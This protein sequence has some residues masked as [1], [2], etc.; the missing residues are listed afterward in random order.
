MNKQDGNNVY[1][2]EIVRDL[3][4]KEKTWSNMWIEYDR[5]KFVGDSNFEQVLDYVKN[6]SICIKKI[7]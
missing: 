1:N 5:S 2:A 3:L 7:R 6:N 4:C